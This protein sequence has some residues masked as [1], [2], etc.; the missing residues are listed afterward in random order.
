MELK[1]LR[2]IRKI[3]VLLLAVVPL[4]CFSQK[5]GKPTE[6]LTDEALLDLVQKQTLRYFWDFGHPT[7]GLA[8]ERSNT[9]FGYGHETCTSGGTGFGVMAIIV[10]AERKWIGREEAAARVQ[11][12]A[13]FLFKASNYHGVFSHW[14][15]GETGKTIPFGRKDDGGDLVETAYLFQGL[16]CARAY[17]DKDNAVER[18]L[19]QKIT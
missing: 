13:N 16:L 18:D 19:R 5:T 11:K 12:I 1:I 17:F 6:K 2:M 15:D 3:I 4:L 14:L 8:R 7:S 9:T 10:G